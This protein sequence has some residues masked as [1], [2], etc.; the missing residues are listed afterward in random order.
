MQ[1]DIESILSQLIADKAAVRVRFPDSAAGIPPLAFKVNFPR[2]EIVLQGELHDLCLPESEKTLRQNQALYIPAG[3]WN[4]PNWQAPTTTLSILFSKKKIGFSIQYW[5][6]KMLCGVKKQ[7]VARLGPRV[8]SFLLLAMNEVLAQSKD[9]ATANFI[10]AGLVSHCIDLQGTSL[11]ATPRSRVLFEAIQE[12]IDDHS[13]LPL[14]R[15]EVAKKFHITPNYLSALFQKTGSVG[16]SEYLNH[17]RLER[18]KT[19]LKGYDMK[20]KEIAHTCGFV[21]S[22]YFCRVFRKNTDRSP[23]EY[24]CHYRSLSSKKIK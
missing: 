7:H 21:D 14:T 13:S 6:G 10:F 23:S 3:R 18:A 4:L 12:Y 2:L 24:R 5:D 1:Q 15:E 16:F 8:G 19:L 9:Q 20:V 22:N 11:Q 17:V